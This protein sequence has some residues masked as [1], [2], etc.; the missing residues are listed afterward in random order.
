MS[1]LLLGIIF[2]A[3]LYGAN[4]ACNNIM[5]KVHK[6]NQN[7]LNKLNIPL[8]PIYSWIKFKKE[9]LNN[10]GEDS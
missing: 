3:G 8:Y 10:E 9:N 5:R 6:N 1:T 4:D 2:G 7:E